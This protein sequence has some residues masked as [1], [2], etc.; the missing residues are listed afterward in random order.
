M[1]SMVCEFCS[2]MYDPNS[3]ESTALENLTATR[4]KKSKNLPKQLRILSH[5]ERIEAFIKWNNG[6]VSPLKVVVPPGRNLDERRNSSD[7]SEEAQYNTVLNGIF[8]PRSV[9]SY[10]LNDEEETTTDEE[11][12]A[13]GG[14]GMAEELS[15]SLLPDVVF[16]SGEA[17]DTKPSIVFI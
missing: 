4:L 2:M 14:E 16:N 11:I 17:E 6:L 10:D 15:S 9:S 5:E 13:G 12:E 1:N 7:N 8:I 3:S